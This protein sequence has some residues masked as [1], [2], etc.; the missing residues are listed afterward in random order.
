MQGL[1]PLYIKMHL[2]ELEREATPRL[3][4][5][6]AGRRDV[7]PVTGVRAAM[8]TLLRSLH[9]GGLPR[10]VASQRKSYS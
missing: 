10:R 7:S 9:A 4:P 6:R 3:H 8:T 2:K 1:T 5:L